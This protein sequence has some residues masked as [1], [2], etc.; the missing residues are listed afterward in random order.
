MTRHRDYHQ[1]PDV[2][3]LLASLRTELETNSDTGLDG[4]HAAGLKVWLFPVWYHRVVCRPNHALRPTIDFCARP[5]TFPR[6]QLIG[7]NL[8]ANLERTTIIWTV[9]KGYISACMHVNVT[10]WTSLDLDDLKEERSLGLW[11]REIRKLKARYGCAVFSP[12]SVNGAG[13]PPIGCITLDTVAGVRLSEDQMQWC[14]LHLSMYT[15]R[16]MEIAM[17]DLG[18]RHLPPRG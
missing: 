10:S 9:G 18:F 4:S 2:E 14:G 13:V 7:E 6:M 3:A 1:S 8:G 17:D 16:V 12:I 5:V 15:E 11:P